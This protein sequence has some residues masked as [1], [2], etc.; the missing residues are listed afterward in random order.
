M[1]LISLWTN[2]DHNFDGGALNAWLGVHSIKYI[3]S[4]GFYCNRSSVNY[5][6]LCVLTLVLQ[7]CMPRTHTEYIFS[8]SRDHELF[9]IYLHLFND[10]FTTL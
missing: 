10:I 8:E 6:A 5:D 4:I 2:F 1:S 7:L 9:K 3:Y